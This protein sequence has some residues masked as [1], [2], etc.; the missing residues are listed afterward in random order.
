LRDVQY[1]RPESLN[2]ALKLL[3]KH[4]GDIKVLAGGTD[5]IVALREKNVSCANILDI[6]AIA[7][8]G[9]IRFS[10]VKGLSIGAAVCLNDLIGSEIVRKYYSILVTAAKTL[11]NSLIR[12]RATLAGNLCNASPGGD[13]LCPAIVLE[14]TVE[15]ASAGRV[16]RLPLC[17]FFTGVKKTVL[18]EDEMVTRVNFPVMSGEGRYLRKSRIK[19]HD[20]AQISV[21]AFLKDE[22]GLNIAV[23]AAGPV[24]V[25]I[26]GFRQCRKA[27]LPALKDEITEK[28]AG[29]IRPIGDQRA[30]REYRQA[31][32]AYL[33]GLIVGELGME[34]PT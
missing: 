4:A 28:V 20:L 15:A 32:A 33:T 3:H 31:M 6:K 18:K 11:A 10:P 27:D 34:V 23:G 14:G 5:L 7:E 24:P 13:M 29:E 22:G 21:A 30:S 2:E 9:E 19:G 17:D 1:F 26:Q 25:V 12:N 8:L 16:R